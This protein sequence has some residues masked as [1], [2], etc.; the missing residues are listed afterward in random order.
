[1]KLLDTYKTYGDFVFVSGPSATKEQ[2]REAKHILCL[3]VRNTQE[4]F[5]KTIKNLHFI[6]K[7]NATYTDEFHTYVGWTYGW[8][9][10]LSE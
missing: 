4:Q 5:G 3:S 9:G 8:K 2:L 1:M 10:D 7:P 6:Y